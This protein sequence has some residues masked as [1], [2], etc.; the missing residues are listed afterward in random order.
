MVAGN[1]NY[2][3][4]LLTTTLEIYLSKMPK[5]TIFNSIPLLDQLQK[6]GKKTQKGGTIWLEPIMYEGNETGESYSG[7]DRQ[8][9]SP[10]EGFTNAQFGP[11]Y[12]RWALAI[13]NQQLS[14]NSGDAQVIDILSIKWRQLEKSARNLI[15]ADL[16]LAGTANG[17]KTLTGLALAVDSSGTYGNI[18]RS[19]NSWWSAVE[20]PVAGTLQ[21]TGSTGLRRFW[22]DLSNGQGSENPD[23]F[24]TTSAVHEGYEALM[25]PRMQFTNRGAQDVGY[26]G[27][28]GLVFKEKPIYWDDACQSGVLYGLNLDYL[29]LRVVP[30]DDFS[31]GAFKEPIDQRGKVAPVYWSG[32]LVASNCRFLGKLTGLTN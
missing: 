28:G 6:R 4:T 17:G 26:P 8:D 16:Y 20:T 30:G 11:K 14:E 12:Y 15:N 7:W 5:D 13:D 1:A 23:M 32:N 9:I 25:D 29:A 22:N 10:Q 2:L 3:T 18:V 24:L 19:A 21:V 27:S 31:H